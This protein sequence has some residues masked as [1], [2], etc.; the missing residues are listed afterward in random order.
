MRMLENDRLRIFALE[1]GLI[2]AISVAMWYV[3]STIIYP[4][5]GIHIDAP[6]PVRTIVVLAL[7]VA[8]I[9]HRKEDLTEFGLKLSHPA[10]L[11]AA[12]VIAFLGVKLLLVQPLADW[13]IGI[14]SLPRADTGV[15]AHIQG[16]L[17]AYMGWLLVAV[18]VGGFAEEFIF[19]GFLMK[20]I[21]DI[22]TMP[23]IGVAVAVI[24]QAII[25]GSL[26]FYV[27]PAGIV[28]ATISALA[29]GCFFILS[30]RSLIPVMITHALWDSLIFT[31]LYMS[32]GTST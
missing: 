1:F 18:G 29:Y 4:Q 30:K 13:V 9:K 20:R 19:R 2:G 12:L 21:S 16:N 26:H 7:I 28:S 31:L 3:F 32:G 27:G 25:F 11:V 10:W 22:F 8:F 15:F 14:L 24:L 5:L 6:M 23:C 17:A